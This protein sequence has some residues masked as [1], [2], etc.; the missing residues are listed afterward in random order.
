MIPG[1]IFLFHIIFIII[2]FRMR[3]IRDS[4]SSAFI[5]L[6][7]IVILFSVGW[8]VATFIVKLF[9]DPSGFGEYFDRDAISLTVLSIAEFFFYR[10]YF[11][12]LFS[13]S[14]GKGK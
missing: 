9:F 1:I 8:S 10:I 3:Y 12:D 5:D 11:A 14:N 2:V 13:T 7:L 4:I 6:V